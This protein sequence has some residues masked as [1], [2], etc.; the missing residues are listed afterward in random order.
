MS[1]T[2]G[3]IQIDGIKQSLN[4]TAILKL[5]FE[6]HPNARTTEKCVSWYRHQMKKYPE[7]YGLPRGWAPTI[8]HD[9]NTPK[10]YSS[11][12][13]PRKT[14]SSWPDWDQP[15]VGDL[16][17]LAHVVARYVRFLTPAIV[18]ALVEDNER[19]SPLWCD[20]LSRLGVAPSFYLWPLSPCAFPGVRRYAGGTEIAQHRGTVQRSGAPEDAIRLDDNDYPKHLW[21]FVFRGGKFQKFGPS[22][23]S[24]AHLADHKRHGNRGKDEF[25]FPSDAEVSN[26][27]FGLY[28]S[29]ANAV[30]L[31][32]ALI[33]PTDFS[34]PLRNLLQRRAAQLYGSFCN[35]VPPPLSIRAA[36]SLDWELS[37]FVWSE[38]V[39]TMEHVAS[40]MNFRN[41]EMERLL[42][43]PASQVP[44]IAAE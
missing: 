32:T 10:P 38:P 8:R 6:A 26:P 39:G 2:I 12:P 23:Y 43:Q 29:A 7:K 19:R 20:A 24:L 22:G 42:A 40:F 28:T 31:P 37:A 14:S 27:L 35:L 36:P 11:K 18:E 15:T 44:P 41:A 16:L 25:D 3:Q 1:N 33:R 5:V 13:Q 4:N 34:F 17:Q 21:S 30:F 9:S